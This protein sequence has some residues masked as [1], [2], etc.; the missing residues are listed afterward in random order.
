MSTITNFPAQVWYF[1]RILPF[2]LPCILN[3]PLSRQKLIRTKTVSR[4]KNVS[5]SAES[6]TTLTISCSIKQTT[7]CQQNAL[8]WVLYRSHQQVCTAHINENI[9]ATTTRTR[10]T[11]YCTVPISFS[12]SMVSCLVIFT[13]F[14]SCLDTVTGVVWPESGDVS[15]GVLLPYQPPQP[16]NQRLNAL[17]LLSASGF[18]SPVDGDSSFSDF[19]SSSWKD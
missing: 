8:A 17:G 14:M 4:F 16:G 9:Y 2:L 10:N 1:V 19:P 12:L 11:G 7:H 5:F 13:V 15:V 18:E 3:V 6:A